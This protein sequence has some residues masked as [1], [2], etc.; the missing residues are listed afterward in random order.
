MMYCNVIR[1]N[2]AS[3]HVHCCCY[4]PIMCVVVI[5]IGLI[6]ITN[7][8]IFG[9]Y[10]NQYNIQCIFTIYTILIYCNWLGPFLLD[11]SFYSCLPLPPL[12]ANLTLRRLF[13]SPSFF[14]TYFSIFRHT[15]KMWI[16]SC[17]FEYYECYW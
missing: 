14:P 5:V 12:N 7:D 11:S 10:N 17:D 4:I 9:I 13:F 3:K 2:G 1:N 15:N 6:L 8:N 16:K